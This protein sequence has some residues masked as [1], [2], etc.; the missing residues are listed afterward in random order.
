MLRANGKSSPSWSAIAMTSP[1]RRL[2]SRRSKDMKAMHIADRDRLRQELKEAT[3][4]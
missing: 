3:E 1:E 2:S 4:Q